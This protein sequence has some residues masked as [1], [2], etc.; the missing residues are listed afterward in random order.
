MCRSGYGHCNDFR[1]VLFNFSTTCS[2]RGGEAA[3]CE[4]G[5]F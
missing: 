2:N 5:I 4:A 1:T 3:R